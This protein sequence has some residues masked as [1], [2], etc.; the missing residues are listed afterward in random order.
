MFLLFKKGEGFVL[1]RKN[2]TSSSSLNQINSNIKNELSSPT[3]P[4]NNSIELS[5][6][7]V[8][9]RKPE[10]NDDFCYI[11]WIIFNNCLEWHSSSKQRSILTWISSI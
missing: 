4:I 9:S 10:S 1:H 8:S 2:T 6:N 7:N 11:S 3:M 5:A